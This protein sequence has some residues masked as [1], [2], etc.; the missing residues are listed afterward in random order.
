[1]L[2]ISNLSLNYGNVSALNSIDLSVE[3]GETCAVIGASGCGKTSIIN[4]LAG[5]LKNYSGT[6]TLDGEKIDYRKKN[7]GLIQQDYG[8]LH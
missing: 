6:I 1:M 8:L 4:I 5:N 7:I 3:S 2:S